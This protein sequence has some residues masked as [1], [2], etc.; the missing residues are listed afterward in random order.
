MVES[1]N[2]RAGR[3]ENRETI[4]QAR[5][6]IACLHVHVATGALSTRTLGSKN[7]MPESSCWKTTTAKH[8]KRRSSKW[9]S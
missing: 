3:K 8:P 7:L 9:R 5:K 6:P 1:A 2:R 4:I